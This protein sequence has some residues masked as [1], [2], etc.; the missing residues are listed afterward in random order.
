[1]QSVPSSWANPKVIAAYPIIFPAAWIDTFDDIFA[2]VPLSHAGEA[3]AFN[4]GLRKRRHV[5]VQQ[6][7]E[8]NTPFL[9]ARNQEWR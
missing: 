9:D 3:P 6:C 4:F 8:G 7:F 5:D 2:V 1:M